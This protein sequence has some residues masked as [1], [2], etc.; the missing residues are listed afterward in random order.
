MSAL[1]VI[2]G[3]TL[4]IRITSNCLQR[5]LPIFAECGTDFVELDLPRAS[6]QTLSH[7][8]EIT[9]QLST[10]HRIEEDG[11]MNICTVAGSSDL[12]LAPK[13]VIPPFF[14]LFPFPILIQAKPGFKSLDESNTPLASFYR[15][16]FKVSRRIYAIP[17]WKPVGT[18]R[19]PYVYYRI[20]EC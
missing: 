12:I 6:Q 13:E 14:P 11:I 8:L 2:T 9:H 16:N 7:V 19:S 20:T 5:R 15:N 17:T 10:W 3:T 1:V 4:N 18:L